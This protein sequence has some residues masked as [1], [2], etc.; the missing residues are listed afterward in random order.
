MPAKVDAGGKNT[1]CQKKGYSREGRVGEC[2]MGGG[3]GFRDDGAIGK[4]V[5][6]VEL[7]P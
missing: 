4:G 1:A 3:G 6:Y 2:W 5:G 7:V